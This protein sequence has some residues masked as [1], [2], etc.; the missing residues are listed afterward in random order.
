MYGCLLKILLTTPFYPPDKGGIANHVLHL[1]HHLSQNHNVTVLRNNSDCGISHARIHKEVKVVSLRSITLPPYP[2]PTM[3]SLKLPLSI[4]K[5]KSTIEEEKPDI[6]HVHGHHY[7]LTWL[8]IFYAKRKRIPTLM[9]LHGMYAL[10]PY[11]QGGRTLV[12]EVFNRTLFR[13]ALENCNSIIGLS[14]TLLKYAMQYGPQTAKYYQIPNG[15]DIDLYN[16]NL[17]NKWRYR[18]KYNLPFNRIIIIFSGRFTH[19]KGVLEAAYAA[20]HITKINPELFFLFVGDGPLKN[21][22]HTILEGVN[23]VKIFDWIPVSVIHELYIASDILILPSKWEA[24]P[25]TMIEAMAARLF[26][27]ATP[28]GGMLDVLKD[29]PLKKL[30]IGN[31]SDS[32]VNALKELTRSTTGITNVNQIND[33][34]E[35]AIEQYDWIRIIEKLEYVYDSAR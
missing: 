2:F 6:I 35:I 8:S 3:T 17:K 29:Y 4:N 19:V 16:R 21:H 7:P 9:T 23:N 24:L 18:K 25:I 27:I 31:H 28:V 1:A 20:K 15:V 12:E 13:K 26:I 5:I 11:I 33:L 30:L 14:Q 32:I 34:V 10:N 22:V